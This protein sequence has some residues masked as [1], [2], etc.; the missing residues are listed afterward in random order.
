MI[1]T[2]VVF[3]MVSAAVKSAFPHAK[4]Q[5]IMKRIQKFSNEHPEVDDKLFAG[6]FL[7]ATQQPKISKLFPKKT[8]VQNYLKGQGAKQ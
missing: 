7:K 8:G 6:V 1:N 3:P 2:K 4:D 5:E